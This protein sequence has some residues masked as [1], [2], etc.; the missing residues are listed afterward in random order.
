[1]ARIEVSV[2]DATATVE[3]VV[4]GLVAPTRADFERDVLPV[5]TRA[6]CNAGTCHASQYGK[7]GFVLSVMAFDPEVDFNSIAI[8]SR[9]RRICPTNPDGSL[10]LAHERAGAFGIRLRALHA[11]GRGEISSQK[12]L[13]PLVVGVGVVRLRPTLA[14]DRLGCGDLVAESLHIKAD[15]IQMGLCLC[16][17]SLIRPGIQLEKQITLFHGLVV[18][19]MNAGDRSTHLWGD[20]DDIGANLGILG[21]GEGLQVLPN[22]ENHKGSGNCNHEAEN[23]HERAGLLRFGI[24]RAEKKT[25]HTLPVRAAKRQ[26]YMM[27]DGRRTEARPN[28]DR[29]SPSNHVPRA[30]A[31]MQASQAGK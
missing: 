20:T 1:V 6:G 2:G 4:S 8:A 29:N 15:Q 30:P 17:S 7:G 14:Q 23:P 13:E 21:A 27:A 11:V 22:R 5:L 26:G 3:V 10:L 24:H 18:C 16:R 9:G 25:S 19:D 31:I 12:R 28:R